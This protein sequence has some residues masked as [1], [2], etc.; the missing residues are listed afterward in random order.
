MP[1]TIRILIFRQMR[2][3]DATIWKPLAK[4]VAFIPCVV[5]PAC[6]PN[7]IPISLGFVKS[8]IHK[9]D[10]LPG[11]PEYPKQ[12]TLCC[13]YSLFWGYWAI[14]LGSYEGRGKR[15]IL[16]GCTSEAWLHEFVEPC[17]S[18]PRGPLVTFRCLDQA[19]HSRLFRASAPNSK[20]HSEPSARNPQK[21][22]I[23]TKP[24]L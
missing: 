6:M 14:V 22:P 12:W 11:P 7:S 20:P 5:V 21:G 2:S 24:I 17:C 8:Y 23:N 4:S 16:K 13:L 18:A 19:T 9:P 3:T 1:S 10:D 15:C